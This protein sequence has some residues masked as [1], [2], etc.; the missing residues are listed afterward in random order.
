MVVFHSGGWRSEKD[1]LER[2]VQCLAW[3]VAQHEGCVGGLVH[4][5]LCILCAKC[6]L[7]RFPLCLKNCPTV[8]AGLNAILARV[9]LP[10][11]FFVAADGNRVPQGSTCN[12]PPWLVPRRN[13]GLCGGLKF[14][15]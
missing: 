4:P 11:S 7:A 15:L 9:I 13:S 1:G 14:G 5:G 2:P 10:R 6:L 12:G 3:D 8:L